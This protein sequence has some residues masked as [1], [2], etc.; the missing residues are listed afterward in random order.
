MA[1]KKPELYISLIALVLSVIATASSIYFSNVNFKTG[2]MPALVFLHDNAGGW[3]VSNVGNGPALNVV[4]A[5]RNKGENEWKAPTALYP[6]SR[7]GKVYTPWVGRSPEKLMVLYTDV[8]NRS[9]VSLTDSGRTTVSEKKMTP[10]WNEDEVVSI[11][12]RR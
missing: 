3:Y 6:V 8:W 7:D 4:A 9:Y 2:A 11:D 1:K 10:P 12:D 5:H